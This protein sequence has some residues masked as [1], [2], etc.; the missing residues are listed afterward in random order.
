VRGDFLSPVVRALV[1][2]DLIRP[3]QPFAYGGDRGAALEGAWKEG[4][5]GWLDRSFADLWAGER[6]GWRPSLA[7]S[8]MLVEDGRQLVISNLSL[9]RAMLNL[10]REP[11]GAADAVLSK[12]GLEFFKLFDLAGR[13]PKAVRRQFKLA[14]AAR[15]SAT[16]PYLFPAVPLPTAPR[17]RVVDAGYYDNYGV[18]LAAGWLFTHVGWLKERV[19]HVAVVHIR[20]GVST[21]ERQMLRPAAD[22]AG[23]FGL[24][25]EPLT[26]PPVGLNASRTAAGTFRNDNLL[27]L[28]NLFF[29]DHGLP[30]VTAA[31]EF[32]G[33][34]DVSLNFTLPPEEA[35]LIDGDKGIGHKDVQDAVKAFVDWW[36]T[37]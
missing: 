33:G 32:P 18:C 5:G 24:A 20:D 36:P 2:N 9:R 30:F 17:R 26:A 8:P 19:S 15:M 27:H 7:F 3:L 10:G 25:A 23:A 35:E 6:D 16:F 22:T 29:R 11:G 31:F 13:D 28:L 12:E 14:T 21:D 1:K 37:G 34:A 4:L